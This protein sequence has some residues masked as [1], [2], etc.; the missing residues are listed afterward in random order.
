M[1]ADE[2]DDTDMTADEFDRR[3]EAGIPADVPSLD[4]V[5]LVVED[6]RSAASGRR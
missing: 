5:T 4:T 1:T 3:M 6:P 2:P